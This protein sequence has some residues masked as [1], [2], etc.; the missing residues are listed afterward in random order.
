MRQQVFQ[1]ENPKTEKSGLEK[2][3]KLAW[4]IARTLVARG[5]QAR[6]SK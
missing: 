4:D 1:E 2:S 3:S 5:Q 6:P